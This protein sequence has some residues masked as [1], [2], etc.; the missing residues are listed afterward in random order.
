MYNNHAILSHLQ[1]SGVMITAVT[2]L[3]NT[4]TYVISQGECNNQ[5]S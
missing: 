5:M 3:H 4:T 1:L 2:K